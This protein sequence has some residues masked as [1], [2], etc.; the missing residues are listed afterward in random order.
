MNSLG[1]QNNIWKRS[2]SELLIAFL[3]AIAFI[4]TYQFVLAQPQIVE[5][6]DTDIIYEEE[7][8]LKYGYDASAHYFETIKLKPNQF[9]GDILEA[10]GVNY[11]RISEVEQQS[12]DVYSV[13]RMKAGK[14]LTLVRSDTCAALSSMVY[15]PD[16]YTYVV[17]NVEE[18]VNVCMFNRPIRS[19]VE[20]ASGTIETSLWNDMIRHGHSPSLIDHMEDAL[21]WSIDFHHTLKGDQYKL[22]FEQKYIDEQP[23]G[24][25]K[26]L[27]AYYKNYDN[28]FYAIYYENENYEG[29]YDLEGRPTKK[30]FLKSPVKFSRISSRFSYSR[31]HPIKK[32]RMPHLGTDYAAPYGTPIRSVAN[33]VV[34]AANYTRGNG[35][36]VK[37]KHDHTYQTQ[38]LH[39]QKFAKGIRPGVHVKQGQTI[40]YVGS[41]GLA[42]GPH[43]CFRFWKN[44]KQINHFRENFPPADPMPE[45]ELPKFYDV[46]Y[47]MVRQLN[48]IPLFEEDV[49]LLVDNYN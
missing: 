25:G 20:I 46:S 38:Y 6:P 28:E 12:K 5:D 8:M 29:F 30:S 17:Y 49:N 9:I 24:I 43:V 33:G 45:S 19:C 18:P 41:T 10:N 40:G 13:R 34:V 42:T 22:I 47:D 31:F 48:M 44:G 1:Q 26:L 14:Y 39:M 32:R 23:V 16:P 27:G 2:I 3:I 21:A 4:F 15:E 37:V 36:Y 7:P 11:S 35:R